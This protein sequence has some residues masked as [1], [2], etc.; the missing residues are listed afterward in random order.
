[1]DLDGLA[2]LREVYQRK[3][4]FSY[5]AEKSN[6]RPSQSEKEKMIMNNW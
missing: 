5:G 2:V 6:G 1:M 3:L 4:A